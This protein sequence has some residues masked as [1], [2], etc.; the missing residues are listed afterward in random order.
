MNNG[1]MKK[2][3]SRTATIDDVEEETFIALCEF[4]YK[5][6]YTTPCHKEKENDSQFD[7]ESK[8]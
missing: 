1:Y 5:G 4:G 3:I 2:E 6:N 7:A 8:Y